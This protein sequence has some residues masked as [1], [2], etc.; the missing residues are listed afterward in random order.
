MRQKSFEA[1]FFF[2]RDQ[3]FLCFVFDSSLKAFNF[4]YKV[5]SYYSNLIKASFD[6]YLLIY[7][8]WAIKMDCRAI[9]VL[10]L[11]DYFY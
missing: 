8:F 3:D 6:V 5:C 10:Y 2:E 11:P 1:V 4:I 7:I 9:I